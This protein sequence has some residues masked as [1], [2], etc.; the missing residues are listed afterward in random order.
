MNYLRQLSSEIFEIQNADQDRRAS[1]ILKRVKTYVDAHLG[2][3]LSLLKL[4]DIMFFNPSYLSRLFK[5]LSGE[6]L[7]GYIQAK[8][9]EKAKSM[10]GR[11]E[12]RVN[13]IAVAVGFG[14]AT[15]F[16]RFFKKET[17]MTPAEYRDRLSDRKAGIEM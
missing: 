12:H 9:I 16:T 8:R 17:G 10:L 6:N 3:D 2:D 15:N 14:S 5:Q 11:N 4:S 1:D 7:T 13:D